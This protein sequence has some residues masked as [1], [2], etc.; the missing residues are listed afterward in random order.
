MHKQ[1]LIQQS[2]DEMEADSAR[3]QW[4]GCTLSGAR[5]CLTWE[6]LHMVQ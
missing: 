5:T 6:T 2:N 4:N 1:H 3:F